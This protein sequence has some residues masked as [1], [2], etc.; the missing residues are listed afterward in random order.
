MYKAIIFDLD[1][2]LLNFST[3]ETESMKRTCNDHNLFVDSVVE[4][5]LF[6]G[7]FSEH[8]FRHWMDFV[9]GGE[10]KTIGDVLRFS[11]RDS[12]NL[13]ELFHSHLSDTYWNYFCNS[14][15]FE[16]FASRI[17]VTLVVSKGSSPL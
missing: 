9:N 7:S 3:C 8:N 12:L 16:V 10:V 13:E 2:T 1:N 15:F 17:L 5:D 6:W 14:C 4:W 11:F